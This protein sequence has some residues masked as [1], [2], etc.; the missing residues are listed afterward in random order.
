MKACSKCGG[1]KPLEAFDRKADGKFGRHPQCK[2]CRSAY[3]RADYLRRPE[4]HRRKSLAWRTAN[5]DGDRVRNLRKNFGLT[6][7][8]YDQML[9][10]QHGVCAVCGMPPVE[11]QR[12]VVDHD[13]ACCPTRAKSCGGCIRGL[14][15]SR[16]N[17]LIGQADDNPQTLRSAAD[18]LDTYDRKATFA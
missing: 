7:A 12:L 14:L 11:G 2:A 17:L 9:E 13:H 3:N 6:P 16:C 5:P 18:Y 1:E 4:Y 8:R 15:H 10:A